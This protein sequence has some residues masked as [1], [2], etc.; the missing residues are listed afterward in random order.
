MR[1]KNRYLGIEVLFEDGKFLKSI[2]YYDI[3]TAIKDSIQL[4]FGDFLTGAVATSF[5]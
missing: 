5:N 2:D 1:F 4:N 3:V